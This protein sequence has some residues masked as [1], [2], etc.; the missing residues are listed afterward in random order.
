MISEIRALTEL[1]GDA[2]RRLV[3]GYTS[4]AIFR[5]SREESD[6]HLVFALQRVSLPS[7][8]HKHYDHLCPE[9]LESYER[10]PAQGFCFGAY[11]ADQCVGIALAEP[12]HWNR[13]VW[14]WE[15]HVA[16]ACQRSGIGRQLV[17]ALATKAQQSGL[18]TLACETQNTNAPAIDF[19]RSVGFHIDGVDVSYYSNDDLSSGE[20]A[21]FMKRAVT[22]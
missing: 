3:S 4:E 13:S 19:Y 5:V 21:L 9:V 6:L 22:E 8:Y 2:L 20:I 7:P 18:R 1:D 16:H 11:Q 14:V 12:E 15:L 17:E 10:L